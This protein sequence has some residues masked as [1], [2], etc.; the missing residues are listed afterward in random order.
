MKSNNNSACLF[1]FWEASKEVLRKTTSLRLVAVTSQSQKLD[2]IAWPPRNAIRK[3]R[4][5][6]RM[7]INFK[8]ANQ[9]KNTELSYHIRSKSD[10]LIRTLLEPFVSDWRSLVAKTV[11]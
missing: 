1:T 9:G 3:R 8:V 7:D 6:F 10:G 2:L 5:Y 11:P 4:T